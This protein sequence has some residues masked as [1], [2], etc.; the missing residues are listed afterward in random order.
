LQLD[1]TKEIF[2]HVLLTSAAA[3]LYPATN[4]AKEGFNKEYRLISA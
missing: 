4:K 3:A 1:S 2:K